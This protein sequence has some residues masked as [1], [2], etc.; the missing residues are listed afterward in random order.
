M[1]VRLHC[2]ARGDSKGVFCQLVFHG[3]NF[4]CFFLIYI[5]QMDLF[6]SIHIDRCRSLI[7]LEHTASEKI[8]SGR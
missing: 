1:Q 5:N 7:D 6:S 2:S 3:L 4:L 8:H